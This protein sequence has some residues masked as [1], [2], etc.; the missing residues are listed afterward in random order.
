M[1]S[2]D[3]CNFKY[4]RDFLGENG[5]NGQKDGHIINSKPPKSPLQ[6][7][8]NLNLPEIVWDFIDQHTPIHSIGDNEEI[9]P[10]I[11]VDVINFDVE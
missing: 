9:L 4:T 10:A 1:N 5:V 7:K 3:Y 2:C 6:G 11:T 8:E